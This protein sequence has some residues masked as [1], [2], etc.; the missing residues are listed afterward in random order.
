MTL[1]G[2]VIDEIVRQLVDN[3]K[4]RMSDLSIDDGQ[5]KAVRDVLDELEDLRWV[6]RE[7]DRSPTWRLGPMG[8]LHL[9]AGYE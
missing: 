2:N 3:G 5:R 9:V 1:R 7:N 6:E 8:E 4:F